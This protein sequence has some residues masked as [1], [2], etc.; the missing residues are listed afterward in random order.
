MSTMRVVDKHPSPTYQ[1]IVARGL[2]YDRGFT[3]GSEA[4]AKVKLN[5][6]HYKKPGKLASR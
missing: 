3:H 6:D 1:R 4:A 5:I 2:P